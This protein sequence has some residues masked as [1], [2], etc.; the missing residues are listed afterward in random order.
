MIAHS[1]PIS[2][3]DALHSRYVATVGYDNQI[4][5]W[6][7][8]SKRGIARANH[9][10][11]ANQCR[12]SPCGRFL[13]SAS[14]DYTARLWRVPDLQLHTLLSGHDDD[15]EMAC[16]SPDGGLIAT[17][18]RDCTV[19][20]FEPDGHL[21]HR[22]RGHTADVIS[23]EWTG[24]AFE[25]ISAGDDG[26][27]RR[28]CAKTGRSLSKT[29][30]EGAE[31]DTI[32][33]AGPDRVFAGNDEGNIVEISGE[34]VTT[35]PAHGAGIKRVVYEPRR[36][37]LLSAGYDGMVK[38]WS[39]DCRELHLL[40]ESKAPDI[41]WLR[42][43]CFTGDDDVAFGT[44]GSSY[45]T[46]S[47]TRREWDLSGVDDT[48]G[49]N[50]VRAVN[51]S[52]YSVG[53]AGVV[54][55]NGKAIADTGS[56]CN[57]IGDI[58]GIVVTGG[59]AGTLFDAS[60]GRPIHVHHSPLNCSVSVVHDGVTYLLVGTYTGE[61]VVFAQR[62]RDL[63]YVRTVPMHSNAIKGL[64]ASSEMIFSVCASGAASMHELP[65]FEPVRAFDNAH[66]KI[67]NGAAALPDGRFVSVSRDLSLRIWT[68]NGPTEFP[69]PH[70]H[71]IKCV[72]VSPEEG[73][74]ATGTYDG[75]VGLFDWREE[76][77]ISVQRATASG[78]SCVSA[79]PEGRGFLASSYDGRLY[80]I[81]SGV[82]AAL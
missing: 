38:L 78:I 82:L 21:L 64:A 39:A 36:K 45:A 79:G 6:D 26:T 8:R 43:C 56:L 66:R 9:D 58:G 14:S 77:W 32:A 30:F 25:L 61:A 3:V 11:L 18:S 19:G 47:I 27:V 50:A 53:D 63:E 34:S 4:I 48:W 60:S 76:R 37:L 40:V 62:G 33:V 29:D 12:F 65:D 54:W 75:W 46:F 55:R 13:V 69:S 68:I 44:F 2:G 24:R 70:K 7:A 59:Q 51:G 28:W 57:F 1:S 23:V 73:L 31:T 72:A 10:H 41:V 35:I 71:S 67:S 80:S 16:Y 42:S 49:I 52:I 20:I 17:A 22:L 81:Q 15:V 5:L 74:V